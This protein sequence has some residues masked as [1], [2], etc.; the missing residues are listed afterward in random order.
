MNTG[1]SKGTSMLSITP[2]TKEYTTVSLLVALSTIGRHVS[3]A[4]APGSDAHSTYPIFFATI[5]MN[6]IPR[7]SLITS[8]SYTHLT[9]PTICSV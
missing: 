7:S 9:L 8:V 6:T 3:I 5:G 2:V 1:T 4:A